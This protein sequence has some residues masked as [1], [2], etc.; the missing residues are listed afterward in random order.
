M[1]M[2][3]KFGFEKKNLIVTAIAFAVMLAVCLTSGLNIACAFGAALL[4]F[5]LKSVNITLDKDMGVIWSV[6][7]ITLS[8][9]MT[10]KMVQFLLLDAELRAK[11]SD[12]K[13]RL[14]ILCVL[15]FYMVI[16]MLTTRLKQTCMISHIALLA[17][18][19]VNYFVYQSRQIEF[20]VSDLKALSTGLSVASNYHLTLD[21]RAAIVILLSILYIALVRKFTVKF[22]R[23]WLVCLV[24]LFFSVVACVYISSK[25]ATTATESWEQKGT[26][27]NGYIL[28][29]VLGIRDT[30]VAEPEDYSLDEIAELETTYGTTVDAGAEVDSDSQSVDGTADDEDPTIIV[31][32]NESFADLS[33]IG[34]LMTSEEV[35]PFYN[36]LQENT[37]KGYALSSV[38]GAKTPNSEWEFLTGNSMAF[39]PSGSVAYQQYISSKPYS[40][41]STLK[42]RGYTCL[43]MHPYYASGWS[44]NKVYPMMGFDD[45]FF[46]DDFDQ[47]NIIREYITDQ[48]LYDNII[49]QYEDAQAAEEKL[50][51]MS[52]S[53]QNHGGYTD[54]YDNF[55]SDVSYTNGYYAD[56]NQ[57]LS[58]IHQSD[59][60]LENLIT[61]FQS[62][63]DKVEIV[64][65]G[66]HQ[67][68]LNSAFYTQLNHKGLSGLTLDELQDLFEVPYF[69]WTNYDSEEKEIPLT[70]LNY[71]S[72][73]ALEQADIELPP[74]NK[75]L[76][77]MMKEIPAMNS[78]AYYSNEFGEYLHYTD[79]GA[80]SDEE[81]L[82]TYEMLQYNNV[83]DSDDKSSI[84]FPYSDNIS[85]DSDE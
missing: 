9:I 1:R 37:I 23:R 79:E 4:Y 14:N 56:V 65:F 17:F 33:V 70:S 58:L 81:W 24:G 49:N 68:S 40:L 53:M 27:Q 22:K 67:P 48:E 69:I 73:L 29:F 66:D 10:E 20:S 61:Y 30:F 16:L 8:V 15:V 85:T 83:F 62:V 63:D 44:R 3:I 32:M 55:T 13:T 28:N 18:A 7:Q 36:S 71:L 77:E 34:N 80:A 50:F 75:F 41:V 46:I 26:Y 59:Q 39:L 2:K 31:I 47:T 38:F 21:V 5:G 51:V 64:F 84:F 74:Y 82:D 6:I 72:T 43:A 78:R 42:D 60:A 11:I 35:T 19:G 12:N 57:Y 45:M 25:T 52:V 54:V 76:S